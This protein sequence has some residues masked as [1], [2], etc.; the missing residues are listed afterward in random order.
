VYASSGLYGFLKSFLG[1]YGVKNIPK[2]PFDYLKYITYK[3]NIFGDLTPARGDYYE[4]LLSSNVVV[5]A[6][7]HTLCFC[8][9]LNVPFL[10]IDSNSH[11]IRGLLKDIGVDY[12]DY[13]IDFDDLKGGFEFEKV[14]LEFSRDRDLFVNY[15]NLAKESIKVM[16]DEISSDCQK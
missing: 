13:K 5:A 10:Y 6:R 16:F 8:V 7:F 2:M 9:K 3:I 11:K 12:R 1:G 4:R 14:E 15:I